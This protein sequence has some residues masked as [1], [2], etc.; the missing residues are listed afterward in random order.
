[1]NALIIATIAPPIKILV[2]KSPIPNFPPT[3]AAAEATPPTTFLP[4]SNKASLF[5]LAASFLLFLSSSKISL[6]LSSCVLDALLMSPVIF[7]ILSIV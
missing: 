7:T 4:D 2:K 1:M 3:A 6:S 5:F